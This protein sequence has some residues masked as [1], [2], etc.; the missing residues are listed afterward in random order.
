MI[1]PLFYHIRSIRATRNHLDNARENDYNSRI[2]ARGGDGVIFSTRKTIGVFMTKTYAFFDNALFKAL[3]REGKRLGYDIVMFMTVGYNLTE[4]EYDRQEKNIFRFAAIDR[5]DGIIT[6]PDS[7]SYGQF[8]DMLYDVIRR[9]TCPV[10]AIR[11][12]DASLDCVYTDEDIAIRPVVRHLIEHHGKKRICMQAGFVDHDASNRRIEAFRQEMAAHGLPVPESAIC[13]G[14]MWSNCGKIAYEAFFTDPENRPEAVVCANDYMAVGLM[15]ELHSHGIR[16]PEDVIVTG[17]D[18]VSRLGVEEPSLTT[19]EPDYDGMVVHAMELLDRQ[20]RTGWKPH[21]QVKIPLSGKFVLGESCGCG[22]RHPDFF[23]QISAYAMGMLEEQNDSDAMLNNMSIEVGGC[24]DLT[25]LHN[26]LI[27]PRV[28]SPIVRDYYLCLFG[29]PGALM[30]EAGDKACL[31]HAIR[32]HR[33][34]GMPMISFDRSD[35]L[36]PMAERLGEPQMLFL[37]LLHQKGNN[38]G[39][40]M[41]QY[42]PG[43]SPS[44]AF[45]TSNALVSIA[46][47]NIRRRGELMELYEERRLSSITDMM[48]GL[49]NRRGLNEKLQPRWYEM[50]G[51]KVAFVCVD[52]DCLKQIND[53]YGHAAGDYAICLVGKALQEALPTGADVARIGGDEFVVFLP[54]AGNGEADLFAREFERVL[55]RLNQE[56]DRS[57]SVTASLGYAVRRLNGMDTIAQCVQESDRQMYKVKETRHLARR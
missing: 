7:Y 41:I 53:T 57:F 27:G 49:L 12:D 15:R 33:D 50:T 1:P 45:V 32:D 25:E 16:V 44:R 36:P 21:A 38:F 40:S 17:F 54:S 9:A 3:E 37:K 23:R 47:E 39:Y 48:T 19:I 51:R 18:N 55:E 24:D 30:Q 6:V 56:E 11:L 5:L 42:D 4:S 34:C 35:L 43:K 26:V 52:M 20:I 2:K 46:L 14:N 10:V 22:K 29:E 8:R 13:H 28:A 31:V